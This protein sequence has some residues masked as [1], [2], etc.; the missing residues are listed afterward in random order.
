LPK[1]RIELQPAILA[2]YALLNLAILARYE[3]GLTANDQQA[4]FGAA[5]IVLSDLLNEIAAYWLSRH[6]PLLVDRSRLSFIREASAIKVNAK[7]QDAASQ[8][9]NHTDVSMPK[10]PINVPSIPAPLSAQT[11]NPAQLVRD[12]F[13]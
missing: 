6:H 12:W 2:A 3:A 1:S 7:A 9:C 11:R 13:V 10:I 8:F 5:D 4:A